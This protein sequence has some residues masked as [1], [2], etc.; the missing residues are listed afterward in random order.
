MQISKARVQTTYDI[1]GL[2]GENKTYRKRCIIQ[3]NR[4][5]H[6][7]LLTSLTFRPFFAQPTRTW[8]SQTLLFCVCI[9]PS[10]S[11]FLSLLRSERRRHELWLRGRRGKFIRALY[12]LVTLRH[13]AAGQ[14]AVSAEIRFVIEKI[15]TLLGLGTINFFTSQRSL[16]WSAAVKMILV[17]YICIVIG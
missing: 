2:F 1:E 13:A 5:S 4:N 15:R 10:L 14:R 7:S 8:S 17:S 9:T 12:K 11:Y 3:K 16:E 6:V